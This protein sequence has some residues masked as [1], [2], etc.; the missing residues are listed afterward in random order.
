MNPTQL[1]WIKTTAEAAT[2]GNHIFPVMAACE[3]ALESGYGQSA[4]ARQGF[5]LFGMKQ[6]KHPVHGTLNLPTKEFLDGDWE[7]V[8]AAWVKYD[9]FAECFEDR[10]DTL[11]RMAPKYP[12]YAA[13]LAATDP[14]TYVNEVSQ[15]WSSDPQRAAHVIQ[16]Y[17][18]YNAAAENAAWP[19][20]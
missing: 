6:H 19:N 12:H 9:N 4:L 7:V 5:N 18:T 8:Q 16:V 10:M 3:A 15:T 11:R 13:A 14:L 20:T 1:D 2:Q 17:N